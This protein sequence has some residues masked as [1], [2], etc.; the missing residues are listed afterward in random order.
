M[1]DIIDNYSA[2]ADRLIERYEKLA[3][4]AVHAAWKH[5]LPD[6]KSRI[7]DVGAGSGRD[8][9]W[10]AG[11]G[12]SVVAVEPADNLRQKAISLHPHDAIHWI[13]D[14]LPDLNEVHRLEQDFDVKWETAVLKRQ[15]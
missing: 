14:R 9:A 12:H 6:S 8:A 13:N 7:L 10:L 2:N 11:Y 3:P 15:N 1:N 5:L 4:E